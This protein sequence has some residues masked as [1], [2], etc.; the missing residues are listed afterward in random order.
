MA[1]FLVGLLVAA[2]VLW[3][4]FP[5]GCF[6]SDSG[7]GGT[8]QPGECPNSLTHLGIEWPNINT[9]LVLAP[10][11]ALLIGWFVGRVAWKK[12]RTRP[13]RERKPDGWSVTRG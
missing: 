13:K 6:V 9:G 5:L 7:P 1:A 3:V 8:R 10:L 12:L 11:I 4:L 2:L